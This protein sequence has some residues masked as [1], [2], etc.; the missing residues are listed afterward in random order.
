MS[1]KGECRKMSAELNSTIDDWSSSTHV[2]AHGSEPVAEDKS[3]VSV[4]HALL[5][6]GSVCGSNTDESAA[7][8]TGLSFPSSKGA[9]YSRSKASAVTCAISWVWFDDRF[10]SCSSWW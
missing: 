3:E 5:E 10:K 9:I 8:V 2:D 7:S 4:T 6:V 1:P